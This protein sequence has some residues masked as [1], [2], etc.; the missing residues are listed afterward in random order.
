MHIDLEKKHIVRR[1]SVA[2]LMSVFLLPVLVHADIVTCDGP[3]CSFKDLMSTFGSLITTIVTV[4]VAAVAIVMSWA[5][6]KYLTAGGDM[7]KVSEAHKVFSTALKGFIFMIAAYLIVQLL[8][9][10]LGVDSAFNKFDK[11]R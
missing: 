9:S 2:I 10:T 1:A 11:L 8:F 4:G 5:G 3:D 6:F 7:G